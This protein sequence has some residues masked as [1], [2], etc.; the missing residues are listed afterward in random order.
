[1]FDV[2]WVL[3][4]KALVLNGEAPNGQQ[5]PAEDTTDYVAL[6]KKML[7]PNIRQVCPPSHFVTQIWTL[8]NTPSNFTSGSLVDTDRHDALYVCPFNTKQD[9]KK[10]K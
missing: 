2:N 7:D 8:K 1:L 10:K 9:L 4:V 5:E 6:L 3:R